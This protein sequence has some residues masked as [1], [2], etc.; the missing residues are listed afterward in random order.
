MAALEPGPEPGPEPGSGD[1]DSAADRPENEREL[2]VQ[3]V[4][5]FEGWS[6]ITVACDHR[7]FWLLTEV[8][9]VLGVEEPRRLVD[10]LAERW[11]QS[12][13]PNTTVVLNAGDR[14]D[15]LDKLDR[16]HVVLAQE[17]HRKPIMLLGPVA[18]DELCACFDSAVARRLRAHLRDQIVPEFHAWDRATRALEQ[19]IL[20][21]DAA[22]IA[23]NRLEFERRCFEAA[24]LERLLDRLEQPGFVDPE[25]LA[26][27]RVVASELAL[28]GV[29]EDY[30]E[31][32]AHGWLTP[33]QIAERWSGMTA[34][35]VGTLIANLGLKGS[36][37]HS[38]AFLN[39]ARG[40]DRT[41]ISH[42]YSPAAVGLIERELSG[43][44]HRRCAQLDELDELDLTGS[45]T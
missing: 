16:A 11:A 42:V 40:H 7:P 32:L 10:A 45:V 12:C 28:G 5:A 29:L 14:R 26:A 1:H 2:A 33:T 24:V 23:G 20:S 17:D 30:Q 34:M 19:P 9:G 44:G 8:A 37:A 18:V 35:R 36:R 43:R 4:G 25:R 22:T 13:P 3:F 15:L 39:K 31:V 27:H 6:L 41:V 21:V 38:R